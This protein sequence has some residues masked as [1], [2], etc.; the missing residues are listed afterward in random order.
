M[1]R[2]AD[3]HQPTSVEAQ[4]IVDAAEPPYVVQLSRR[5]DAACLVTH[6]AQW[7]LSQYLQT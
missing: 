2:S 3:R 1:A 4:R 5:S 7:L 6:A